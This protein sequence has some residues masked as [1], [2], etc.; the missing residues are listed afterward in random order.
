MEWSL[1]TGEAAKAQAPHQG[2]PGDVSNPAANVAA[3]VTY[4]AMVG[5]THCIQGIYFAY[6]DTPAASLL[7]VVAGGR[8]LFS[9]YITWHGM[10]F[11]PLTK[12]G[13]PGEAMVITLPAGGVGISGSLSIGNHW[14]E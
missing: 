1:I 14:T 10:G 11:L 3:I 2:F 4:A 5:R 6:D 8:V 9:C 12:K 13:L 7:Q